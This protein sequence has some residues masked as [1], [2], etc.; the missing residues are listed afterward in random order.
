MGEAIEGLRAV[1]VTYEWIKEQRRDEAVREFPAAMKL[2]AENGLELFMF[3]E[4]HFRLRF[5]TNCWE[6]YPGELRITARYGR[7]V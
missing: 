3:I 2:A 4:R 7:S 6:V 5:G 1:H